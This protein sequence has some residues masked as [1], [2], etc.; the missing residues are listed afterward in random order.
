[1]PAEVLASLPSIYVSR[2]GESAGLI[3]I[4]ALVGMSVIAES[5]FVLQLFL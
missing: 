2:K 4:Q 5:F 1:M 3:D